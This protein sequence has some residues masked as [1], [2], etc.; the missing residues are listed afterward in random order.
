M[1]KKLIQEQEKDGD[2]YD[3]H[4]VKQEDLLRRDQEEQMIKAEQMND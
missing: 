2:D 3:E 4:S 1:Q